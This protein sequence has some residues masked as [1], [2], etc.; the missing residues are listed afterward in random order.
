M[1]NIELC[2]TVLKKQRKL[3]ELG[4]FLDK[5]NYF[6]CVYVCVFVCDYISTFFHENYNTQTKLWPSNHN[7]RYICM[8]GLKSIL[9]LNCFVEK[10]SHTC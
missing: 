7:F 3:N 5:I 10:L 4:Y 8:C 6:V 2:Y 9:Y 1:H